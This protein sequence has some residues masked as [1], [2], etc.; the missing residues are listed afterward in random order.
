MAFLWD[1]LNPGKWFQRLTP[2]QSCG[3]IRLACL[4]HGQNYFNS[5][6]IVIEVY[7]LFV[8]GFVPDLLNPGFSNAQVFT[9]QTPSQ[10]HFPLF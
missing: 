10:P 7:F 3:N 5:G 9:C 2:W 1:H 6:F 4:D 8:F